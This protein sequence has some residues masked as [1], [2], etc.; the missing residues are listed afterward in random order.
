MTDVTDP[1]CWICR[2]DAATSGEHK[3]KRSDLAAVL[4][5]PSQEHPLY[6]H[7][8]ERQNKPV[9]SLDAKILKAPKFICHDCNTTRTQPHDRAWEQ[10]SERL[11]RCRL[12][13]G[14]WVRANRIFTYEPRRQMIDVHLFFIKLFGCMLTE[15]TANGYDVPIDIAP[16]SEAIMTGRPH[17]E[18]LLQFGICDG[19]VGRTDLHCWK[20]DEEAVIAGWL[21]QLDR[22]AVSVVFAQAGRWEPSADFWHPRSPTNSKRFRI[23]D[24]RY[25]HLA[26]TEEQ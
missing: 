4:R 9:K 3:T 20:T 14:H 10:M 25:A 7:D 21:Y 24:F 11:R 5:K 18:V 15:A 6:F 2:Q 8:L 13:V 16:F 26:A 1:L 23:A 22:I 12:E 17:P 19:I